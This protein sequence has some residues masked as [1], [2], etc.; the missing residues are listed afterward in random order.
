MKINREGFQI[1]A[2]TG[3]VS[4]AMAGACWL[5]FPMWAAIMFTILLA[6]NLAFVCWFFREPQ[7]PQHSDGSIVYSPADGKIVVVERTIEQGVPGRRA[8][9]GFG[10]YVRYQR[11]CQLVSGERHV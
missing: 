10:L 2:V 1:I 5:V 6:V 11:A 9:T 4:A 3:A 7:R 8:D